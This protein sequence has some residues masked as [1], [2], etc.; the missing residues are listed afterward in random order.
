MPAVPKR[1]ASSQH[2]IALTAVQIIRMSAGEMFPQIG[3]KSTSAV[4]N[5]EGSL[6]EVGSAEV[7]QTDA[8]SANRYYASVEGTS[9]AAESSRPQVGADRRARF[10]CLIVHHERV[11]L[12]CA[13]VRRPGFSLRVS[14]RRC[15][16]TVAVGVVRRVG[17]THRRT[18]EP[19]DGSVVPASP[20]VAERVLDS[21][22]RQAR[23]DRSHRSRGTTSDKAEGG[24]PGGT[25][26]V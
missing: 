7:G 15:E 2:K 17:G 19:T 22:S 25:A 12:A 21:L 8:C 9:A 18:F 6:S 3:P 23:I 26:F 13:S 14:Q 4:V 16:E 11:S 10:V 5:T 1:S 20:L 24:I